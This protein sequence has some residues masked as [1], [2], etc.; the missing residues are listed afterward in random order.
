MIETIEF[1]PIYKHNI[2]INE[3]EKLTFTSSKNAYKYAR[4]ILHKRHK[5]VE[6]CILKEKDAHFAM[7]YAKDVVK[8]RWKE[9]EEII[10]QDIYN[11]IDYS[12]FCIKGRW[13]A[14]EKAL[15]NYNGSIDNSINKDDWEVYETKSRLMVAYAEK[16]I[17]GRWKKVE[18][19]IIL[20]DRH[21]YIYWEKVMKR[22]RWKEA[23]KY[24][25]FID[26]IEYIK[27]NLE[28]R[29]SEQLEKKML[30]DRE[31]CYQAKDLIEYAVK[32]IKGRWI[33]AEPIILKYVDDTKE[34]YEKIMKKKWPE[35]ELVINNHLVILK[36]SYEKF[37]YKNIPWNYN[38]CNKKEEKIWWKQR[39]LRYK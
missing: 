10:L 7:W 12:L 18:T 19:F 26:R 14:G 35:G 1:Y 13:K 16:V 37:M 31:Y 38:K 20:S 8:G 25:H 33:E 24:G 32:I 5:D 21:D 28:G 22:K 34:Y 11:V 6:E 39:E 4:S 3:N 2:K 36:D 29:R 30:C 27:N 23:E 15:L 9:A 17:K